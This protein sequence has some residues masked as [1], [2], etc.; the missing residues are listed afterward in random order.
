MQDVIQSKVKK[1]FYLSKCGRKGEEAA[2]LLF[3][4]GDNLN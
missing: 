4:F 2:V 1:G 3:F